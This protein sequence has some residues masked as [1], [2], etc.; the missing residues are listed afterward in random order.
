MREKLV[1]FNEFAFLVKV[2]KWKDVKGQN[3]H[4][5]KVDDGFDEESL[6]AC[7]EIH[8]VYMQ[9]QLVLSFV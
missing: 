2:R 3:L 8:N 6:L 9:T 4:S 5:F 7:L 1:I